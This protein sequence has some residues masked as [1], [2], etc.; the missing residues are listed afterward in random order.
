MTSTFCVFSAKTVPEKL[1]TT[2]AFLEALK[3]ADKEVLYENNM[4]STG[5]FLRINA[6]KKNSI[7]VVQGDVMRADMK[8]IYE[9]RIEK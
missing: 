7:D 1:R 5:I 6:Q 3:R 4:V 8:K 2:L 9:E